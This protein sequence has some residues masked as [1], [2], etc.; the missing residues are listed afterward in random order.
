MNSAADVWD[1]VLGI[2]SKDLTAT[3]IS[4]WFDDCRAVEILDSRLFLHTPTGFKKNI[5]EGRFMGSIKSAL[6]ELF[7]GEYDVILLDD[8]E[9]AAMNEAPSISEYLGVNEY[10]FAR[11]L[12]GNSNKFAHA[13]AIAVSEGQHKQNYNPLF[14]YGESGLGKTHLLHAI[15]HAVASKFPSSKTVYVKGEDFTNEL[16][17]A[18]RHGKNVEFREKYRS[19]DFFLIDDIQFIA[20]K[21]ETQEE[22]FNTF[23][24]LYEL[25]KQIVFTSDRPPQEMSRLE[26]RL[27]SRFESGLLADIQPPD[28]A[29]RVAII[30]NKAEQHG[31]FLPDDVVNYIAE[32]LNSNVRQLEG[33]VKMIIAA[34]DIMDD[35]ITVDSVTKR[36]KDMFKGTKELIPTVDTIIEETA[37]FHN[38][39]PE[40]LKGK[41]RTR[42]TALARHV[43]MFLI[44]RLTN[45]SLNDIG[46]IFDGRDHTTVLSSLRRVEASMK[47]DPNF[48]KIIREITSNINSKL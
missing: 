41:R 37:R 8:A 5:I 44:R 2:L 46:D 34:R 21:M 11:F 38:L 26:D 9:L 24:T 13:A 16:I 36:L 7:S 19:A 23:N 25:G 30:K 45:L 33:A 6:D 18:I 40:D 14:I 10:T 17:L 32:N 4:T 22:F 29:L 35:D 27:K 15:R 12:V 39:T 28:D 20:G 31:V 1:K 47:D 48:S 43:S 42:E 3:A